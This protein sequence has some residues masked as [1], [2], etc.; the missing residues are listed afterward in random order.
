MGSLRRKLQPLAVADSGAGAAGRTIGVARVDYSG[1]ADP[2]PGAW[3]RLAKMARRDFNT[4]VKLTTVKTPQ[5]DPKEMPLAHLTGSNRVTFTEED[6]RGLRAYADRGGLLFIDAAGGNADF[7]ASCQELIGKMYPEGKLESLPPDHP[8]YLGT[9]PDGVKLGDVEFRKYGN[10]KLKR[11]VTSPELEA[12]TVDGK[13][14]I[15][16]SRWDI[17]SGFLGTNTWGVMGFAPATAEALG[18]NI[19]LYSAGPAVAGPGARTGVVP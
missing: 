19:L 4:T 13:I 16:F 11:R 15:L 1:N 3:A 5:L 12:V 8:I 2:E 18:R 14:R 17:C 7:V 9:M 6:A 10:M